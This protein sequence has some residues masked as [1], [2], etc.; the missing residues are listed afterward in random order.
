MQ[1]TY[2]LTSAQEMSTEIM[3][4]I[5][6]AFQSKP[7]TITVADDV[8]DYELSDEMKQVLDAR[9]QEEE[10]QYLTTKDSIE[11]L[12]KKYGGL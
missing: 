9:L 4:A 11:R 3:D 1:T 6:A 7:I 12:Q 10:S 2:R 8:D 5:K